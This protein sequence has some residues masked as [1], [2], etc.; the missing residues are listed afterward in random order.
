MSAVAAA[1][2]VAAMSAAVTAMFL[3]CCAVLFSVRVGVRCAL[4]LVERQLEGLQGAL[5]MLNGLVELPAHRAQVPL[6]KGNERLSVVFA[7]LLH[8]SISHSAGSQYWN[9]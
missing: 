5:H 6:L 1:A 4:R 9:F 8:Y 3:P 2:A 7:R